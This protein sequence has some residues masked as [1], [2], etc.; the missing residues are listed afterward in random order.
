MEEVGPGI[1]I[2]RSNTP[3]PRSF[4]AMIS[5]SGYLQK[6][7]QGELPPDFPAKAPSAPPLPEE[8]DEDNVEM[9]DLSNTGAS[10]D[11]PVETSEQSGHISGLFFADLAPSHEQTD[12]F[13]L[14]EY[15]L[16]MDAAILNSQER[17]GGQ[18]FWYGPAVLK[19]YRLMIG[20]QRIHNSRGPT[21]ISIVPTPDN[22]GE[23]WGVL[24]RVPRFLLESVDGDPSLLDTIHAAIAPQKF[25]TPVEVVVQ[26]IQQQHSVTS[27]TYIATD[28]ARQ[29]LQLVETDQWY[30]DPQ[31]MQRMVEIARQQKLPEAYI[32]QYLMPALTTTGRLPL[33]NMAEPH[34]AH[35]THTAHNAYELPSLPRSSPGIY[36]APSIPPS[37]PSTNPGRDASFVPKD[38]QTDAL[39]A[40][41]DNL[42][43]TTSRLAVRR[44]EA[45]RDQRWLIAFSLY[46]VGLLLLLL[47]LAIVQGV[48]A[49]R[50]TLLGD[51][52]P[53]GVP[54]QVLVYGLFGG[55]LSCIVSL[56][57][58]RTNI[59]PLFVMITWFTRPFVGSIL[60]VFSYIFLTSG[61]FLSTG[62]FARHPGFFWLIGTLAGL[63]EWL[64]FC[65]RR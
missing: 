64:L 51:F 1:P 17:L 43:S 31:L 27:T 53:L 33:V 25:F 20:E 38:L 28:L 15:G 61:L 4:D 24:Y 9:V 46:L 35:N 37:L 54:W 12:F 65:R 16:E 42:L 56:G 22:D 7:Q 23:V 13:W 5:S 34:I 48:G 57:S 32:R 52:S 59:P 19:G 30:G 18:A 58:M 11:Q 50:G 36:S 41:K 60:A 8:L 49:A 47:I 10:S 62:S 39:Q 63:C 6:S 2:V 44:P 29:Q 55:C 40:F 45:P 3:R 14:F 21:I 26:D